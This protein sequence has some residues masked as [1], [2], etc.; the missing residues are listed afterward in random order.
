M[1]AGAEKDGVLQIN[2]GRRHFIRQHACA[3]V[4]GQ[5]AARAEMTGQED[6]VVPT[7]EQVRAQIG[8][9]PRGRI[10][11]RLAWG[12]D[13]RVRGSPNSGLERGLHRLGVVS[14]EVIAGDQSARRCVH[15]ASGR[16]QVGVHHA[17]DLGRGLHQA[18]DG[19]VRHWESGYFLI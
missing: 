2:R 18:P 16:C 19:Q 6:E 10:G 12:G 5:R 4:G 13:Q 3:E 9:R 15:D 11:R 14:Q 8:G 7:A 1:T 17:D